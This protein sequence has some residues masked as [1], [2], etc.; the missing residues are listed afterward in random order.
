MTKEKNNDYIEELI[1]DEYLEWGVGDNIMILAGT[2]KG[3]SHFIKTILNKH[4]KQTQKRVLLLTNREILKNQVRKDLGLNTIITVLNYQK[5]ESMLLRNVSLKNY[6]YIVMDEC[7]YFFTD[8]AFN[9]KTD[10]FFKWM[11]S[12]NDV[13]KIFM[14]ATPDN[15]LY[16]FKHNGIKVDY[17]YELDT[18]YSYLSDIYAFDDYDT[19]NG[20]IEDIPQDEQILFISRSAK[21][22]YE[23]SKKYNGAFICSKYNSQFSEFI[24]QEELNSII[25]KSEFKSHLL[26][27]TPVLDNGI[28]IKEFSNVKYIVLDIFDK[29]TFIQCLGRKRV[30]QGETITLYFKNYNGKQING[31][32][33]KLI[34]GLKLADTLK[35][36]GEEEYVKQSFKNDMFYKYNSKIID[37]IWDEDKDASK[38]IINNCMYHKYQSD[39]SVCNAILN[40]GNKYSFKDLIC[41][42]LRIDKRRIMDKE[43]IDEKLTL[44]EYLDSIVGKKL[45]KDEQKVLKQVFEKYGLKARTLG[46]NTLN[47]YLKDIKLNFIIESNRETSKVGGNRFKTYW[48]VGQI[49]F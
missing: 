30:G 6:D 16:Y 39:L 23:I 29:D 19:I 26:C 25:K 1:S 31:F 22:A 43:I 48:R 38:K 44:E 11:L 40:S 45:F 3:K 34:H 28:N 13:C 33:S 37:E 46:I 8:S 9:I 18:D 14:T 10:I 12:N 2:G 49:R 36:F 24:N 35:E 32:K 15:V 5:I 7:H 42:G 4:C 21:R 17:K 47:G 27:S 41:H 20:I